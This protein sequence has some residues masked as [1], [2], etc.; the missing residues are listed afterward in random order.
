MRVDIIDS[1]KAFAA[2]RA[3]WE[4][5]YAAD[6]EA[7]VFLS[8]PWMSRWL[9]VLKAP[10]SVLAARPD[11]GSEYAAFF[12]VTLQTKE[13]E[14]GGFYCDVAMGG[15]YAADYTGFLCR[16]ELEAQAIPAFAE[17]IKELHW[18]NLRLEYVLASERRTGLFLQSFPAEAFGRMELERINPDKVDNS[19]C[20]FAPLPADW[21]AYLAGLS[22]NT[23][24]KIR[25]LLRQFDGA[26]AFRITHADGGTIA[27]DLEILMRFWTDQ[28]GTRK[29][30]NLSAIQRQ[31]RV[32]LRHSFDDGRLLLPVLWQGERP[33]GALSILV[34]PVK[35][36]YSFYI[37]GRDATF[38]GP[39]PGLML[40]AHSIRHAVANGIG[41]YD[42]LR[43]NE[44]YKYSFA[45]GERRLMSLM[46][47][48]RDGSVLATRLD[49]R[50]LK[51]A[52]KRSLEHDKEGRADK[53][54][55]GF[56]QVLEVEPE[57]AEALYGLG[58]I[59]AKRGA[60]AEA[61]PLFRTLLAVSPQTHRAW[62]WLGRSLQARGALAEAAS[63]YCEGIER[64]PAMPGAYVELAHILLALGQFDQALAA[65]DAACAVQ[66][67]FPGADAGRT[68]ALRAR[69]GAS[70]EERARRASLHAEVSDRVSRLGA[71][72]AAT[73]RLASGPPRM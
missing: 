46:L 1:V 9:G 47:T 20:P 45:A 39:S 28:W 4:A 36:T 15:N 32:M 33:I 14:A 71:I 59:L 73:Q 27:R 38:E 5:V 40:H 44:P 52:L 50:S 25:R 18:S 31:T 55:R 3:N 30:K 16:P 53:A 12:P 19:L 21:E 49:R 64:E 29:G 35:R 26:D 23:R 68:K 63:A 70:A 57:S 60:H 7:Q 51:L 34:D 2:L 61:I 69:G 11:D 56:R 42:F 10:W 37:G 67:G 24:Q 8:W 66:P 13:R 54:E 6:P 22:A 43:G 65:F 48:R 72:A 62:F 41:T 58:K 17:R